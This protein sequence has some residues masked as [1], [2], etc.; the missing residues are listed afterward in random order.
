MAD[1]YTKFPMD[2]Y[3]VWEYKFYLDIL[4]LPIQMFTA[5]EF[6]YENAIAR[7]RPLTVNNFRVSAGAS[8]HPDERGDKYV[9]EENEVRPGDEDIPLQFAVNVWNSKVMAVDGKEF[10]RPSIDVLKAQ[11]AKL[12]ALVKDSGLPFL[13]KY[14]TPE[15]PPP[16]PIPTIEELV[17]RGE[18]SELGLAVFEAQQTKERE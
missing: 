8:P 18:A 14:P 9:W 4:G 12:Y 15:P 17:E 11:D 2:P 5:N 16:P 3:L 1:Y 13:D 10:G 7:K 6:T